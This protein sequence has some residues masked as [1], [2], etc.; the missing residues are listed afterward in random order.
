MGGLW[1][2]GCNGWAAVGVQQWMG[3]GDLTLVTSL[4]AG[5]TSPGP[6]LCSGTSVPRQADCNSKKSTGSS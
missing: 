5:Y 2:V 4:P 3:A 1:W 6:G